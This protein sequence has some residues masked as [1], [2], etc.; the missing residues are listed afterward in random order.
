M[1][2][3][4]SISLLSIIFSFFSDINVFDNNQNDCT[5]AFHICSIGDYY[6]SEFDGFGRQEKLNLKNSKLI[7]TNSI[8]LTFTAKTSGELEFTIVPEN[9]Y[10]DIDFVLYKGGKCTNKTPIREMTSGE[11]IGEESNYSC[12]GQTGLQSF[13][14]D[15]SETDGCYN[16]DDNFLKPVYLES[17]ETYYL[18]VNNYNSKNGFSILLSGSEDLLLNKDCENVT[19]DQLDINIS[20]NPATNSVNIEWNQSVDIQTKIQIF[21]QSGKLFFK[22]DQVSLLNSYSIDISNYPP[23]KYLARFFYDKQIKL[24]SFIK[25]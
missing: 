24:K 10:D 13:S 11:I 20:P 19:N 21:D 17:G 7:E 4:F 25:I 12:V 3:L 23:G 14:S 18:L 5:K 8:W 6:F 22:S 1:K 9:A 2:N 15:L 16:L